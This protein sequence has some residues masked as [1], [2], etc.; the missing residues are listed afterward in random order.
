[1]AWRIFLSKDR[2]EFDDENNLTISPVYILFQATT[3]SRVKK[4]DFPLQHSIPKP[5][6]SNLLISVSVAFQNTWDCF[7]KETIAERNLSFLCFGPV[8]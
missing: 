3:N 2:S 7:V 1:M 5:F 8:S 6:S 4:R